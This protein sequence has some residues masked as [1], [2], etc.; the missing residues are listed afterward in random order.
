MNILFLNAILFT[1]EKGVI[2]KM[3]S[4]KD[5]MIYN[6]CLGAKKLGHHVTLAASANYKPIEKEEY[7]VEVLFF[8]SNFTKIFKPSSLPYSIELKHFLKRN[9]AKYDIVISGGVFT[10]QSLM[11]AQICPLKTVLWQ[12]QTEHQ[13]KLFKIPSKIWF[14]LVVPICMKKVKSVVP[15]SFAAYRFTKQYMKQTSSTIV[16]HGINV[17]KF[18]LSDKKKRQIISS[19]QLVYRKNVDGIIE[20]FYHLHNLLGYEDIRLIIAGRGE[21]ENN[22]KQ[23]V[24]KLQLE[25]SVEFVGFLSQAKL[26]EYIR[27]SMALL[28]NTRKD[29]N[30]VSIPES[31]VS[32]TPILTN[33]QPAS[34]EYIDKNHLGIAKNEWGV[35]ELKEIID[36]SA[37]YV[38]NCIKYR[39]NLTTEK[40]VQM[41]IDIFNHAK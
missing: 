3:K 9:H 8:K 10:F 36:N 39:T 13:Q 6:M 15:R 21:E 12:E 24:K 28:V 26:N 17:D 32:G 20:K 27:S 37:F 29:L 33:W 16:D 34:A 4:I 18:V 14:N 2:P 41:L 7:D 23:L 40:S 31:I 5:T 35:E 22:L 25:E 30:M 1:P 19:S 11:A 38:G